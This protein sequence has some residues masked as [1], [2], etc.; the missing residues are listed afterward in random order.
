MAH[1]IDH[2]SCYELYWLIDSKDVTSINTLSYSTVIL[3][4]CPIAD[5]SQSVVSAAIAVP[6][7]ISTQDISTVVM[8]LVSSLYKLIGSRTNE[9]PNTPLSATTLFR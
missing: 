9:A 1:K 7:S 8:I 4:L 5:S 6:I 3:I 2:T